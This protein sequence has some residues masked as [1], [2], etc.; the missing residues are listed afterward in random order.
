M[1]RQI[2]ADY[3]QKP[4]APLHKFRLIVCVPNVR[5]GGAGQKKALERGMRQ[6][7]FGNYPKVQLSL[8]KLR[9]T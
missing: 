1:G 3:Q 2:F 7:L 5:I 6:G 9:S 8:A 4:G